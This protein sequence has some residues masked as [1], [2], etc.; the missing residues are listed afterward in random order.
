[1]S[2][3]SQLKQKAYQAGKNRNWGEAITCYEQILDLEKNNPTVVN[4]LGDLCLKAGEV[5]RAIKN[6]L[7]AASRYRKTG[8]LNNSVAIYK[9]IL[10]HDDSN[11]SAHWYLADTRA[12]QGLVVEGQEH[13]VKFLTG[14]E[15]M[16]GDLAEIFLKRCTKLFELYPASPVILERLVGIFRSR[17]MG[18]ETNRAQILQACCVFQDG[19]EATA[20]DQV[21]N[22]VGTT[23]EVRNY[24]E[25]GRWSQLLDPNAGQANQQA[26][27]NT[28]SFDGPA[29]DAVADAAADAVPTVEIEIDNPAPAAATVEA[30][31]PAP[32][33]GNPDDEDVDCISID[34]EEGADF[35]DLIAAAT[36]EVEASAKDSGEEVFSEP[37]P[38]TPAE[39]AQKP[40]DEDDEKIDLLAQILSEEGGGLGDESAQL[41]TIT[42]EIGSVV[43]GSGDDEDA[44][45]L[46][47][48]G[49]VYL[50]MGLFDQ[51][52]ESFSV[53]ACDEEFALRAHEMWGITMQRASNPD[54]SVRVLTEGL[55][56]AEEG[57]REHLT[58]RYHIARAHEMA[59][60]AEAAQEIYQDICDVNEGF[61]DVKK[62]RD[63]LAGVM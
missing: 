63:E 23:P 15:A 58:L 3:L 12:K 29:T 60:R 61:M 11:L 51:A 1:L 16:A 18:L 13:A 19:D 42:A 2:K 9:K 34:V 56:Y 10:R 40:E 44:G 5:P 38:A 53:A 43:G 45:R 7:T 41:D 37:G 8:L 52:C 28:V 47:E 55:T 59:E 46:Y 6:F 32:D 49:M 62:R 14:G 50:E 27:F 21:E 22:I 48:M 24:P 4:E 17:N 31:T 25:F 35:S 54:E 57:S 33:A 20:K 26:D 36:G 30:G 39:P